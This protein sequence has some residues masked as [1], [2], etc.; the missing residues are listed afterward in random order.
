[1]KYLIFIIPVFIA[2]NP[3]KRVTKHPECFPAD[4]IRENKIVVHYETE[5]ITN[6]SIVYD[7]VQCLPDSIIVNEVVFKTKIRRITDTIKISKQVNRTNPVNAVM[8][9]EN[10]KLERKNQKLKDKIKK[11]RWLW[12]YFFITLAL[13]IFIII[14]SIKK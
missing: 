4:T 13:A 11:N 3:C 7:T 12:Y 2:C 1:M 6:D 10:D 14:L 5:Y 9:D 8:Q